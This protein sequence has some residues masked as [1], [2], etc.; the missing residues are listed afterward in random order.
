MNQLIHS[1]NT[2][3]A[4]PSSE[5]A[6]AV[7]KVAVILTSPR[8]G[9]SLLMSVLARH[10]D[11]ASLDGE[12]EPYLPLTGNGY[13]HNSD[14]DALG[15]LAHPRALADCVLDDLALPTE[16]YAPLDVLKRRWHN[17]ILLQFPALFAQPSEQR[18]LN[19]SLD[20]ALTAASAARHCQR[21]QLQA[22]VLD[23][24]FRHD[25]WRTAY[26][27]GH[28]RSDV[29]G[30]FHTPLKLEEPPFVIPRH[31]A[32]AF[33]AAD[34]A[35]KTLLFKTPPDTYRLGMY[36]QLFPAAK[37]QY[38]HLTRGY[39]QTVNGLMDGWLSPVGFFSHDLQRSGQVLRIG[40]YSELTPFGRRWWKFDLPPNWRDF[41]DA[42]LSEVCLNQWLSPHL[43]VLGAGVPSMRL[44][45]ESF[46]A[47]PA[48]C[49]NRL[50]SHLGLA[51]MAVRATLPVTMATEPP[52]LMRWKK[53]APQLL[54]LAR[55][56]R[57][58]AMMTALG[59][60]MDPEGWL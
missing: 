15:V 59:Y 19:Q 34:A 10:P 57:V 49:V 7:R 43:A 42:E 13:G 22:H 6:G 5:L 31:A 12:I 33:T 20:E 8:S 41:V 9:S 11:I 48:A 53:R 3:R 21:G 35:S 27:D 40:G 2:L 28:G 56:P 1:V 58:E 38:I 52:S 24:V 14:S 60:G 46:L 29:A 17:R 51:P 50:L 16:Q 32:R 18:R 37:I 25:G 47:A 23:K 26:Y 36:E 44:A 4:V 30:G 39:A 54:A 45:F 55:Q